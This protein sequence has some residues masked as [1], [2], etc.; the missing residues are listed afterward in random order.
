MNDGDLRRHDR[1]PSMRGC[2]Q[3]RKPETLLLADEDDSESP[4]VERFERPLIDPGHPTHPWAT[5][6]FG[7][8][9]GQDEM[10]P[11]RFHGLNEALQPLA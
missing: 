2:L 3:H 10:K 7:P 4:C 8:I 11:R 1:S 9:A 5:E 6:A